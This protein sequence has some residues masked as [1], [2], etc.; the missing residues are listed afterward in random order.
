M[1]RFWCPFLEGDVELTNE[2]HNHIVERHPDMIGRLSLHIE[3]TLY[4]P[5]VIQQSVVRS[6]AREFARWYSADRGG[7]YVIVVVVIDLGPP[8]RHWIT[9]AHYTR[10]LGRGPILWVPD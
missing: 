3:E 10:R 4:A 1:E 2:R 5:D 9:T 7:K 6:D 8:V